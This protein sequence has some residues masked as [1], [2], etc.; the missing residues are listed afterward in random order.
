MIAAALI[1]CA[2]QGADMQ[3]IKG[4]WIAEGAVARKGPEALMVA[5]VA[6]EPALRSWARAR[7]ELQA[8]WG[9]DGSSFP[10]AQGLSSLEAADFRGVGEAWLEIDKGDRL[11]LKVGLVDANTEFAT[12]AASS[13]FANPSL[14]L[15][16]ALALLPSYPDPAWSANLFATLGEPGSVVGVGTY[17]NPDGTWSAVTQFNAPMGSLQ[18]S[19]GWVTPMTAESTQRG[20][21]L[22]VERPAEDGISPFVT[23]ASAWE[24][25]MWHVATG[26]TVPLDVP[27]DARWGIATSALLHDDCGD[28]TVA[29]AFIVFRPLPILTIRPDF[30]VRWAQNEKPSPAALIRISLAAM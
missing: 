17:R 26:F 23:V 11:R 24:H 28:D 29:E 6:V 21:Y 22:I 7:V 30:Q 4:Y 19:V 16:P 1:I 8:K 3:A 13:E 20:A 18:W 5:S 12:S 2:L 25:D 27:L 15:S 14:G 9:H 10:S